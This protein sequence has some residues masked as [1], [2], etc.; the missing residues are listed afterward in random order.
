MADSI[1]EESAG[2]ALGLGVTG[3]GNGAPLLPALA[4]SFPVGHSGGSVAQPSASPASSPPAAVTQIGLTAVVPPMSA[5]PAGPGGFDSTFSDSSPPVVAVH[6]SSPLQGV[7]V[8]GVAGA[9]LLTQIH[10][11]SWD[12]T[13]STDWDNE[14]ASPQCI[15]RIKR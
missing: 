12:P 6:A 5:V 15:L 13:V 7:G 1:G 8:G 14:K 9:G 3:Q 10:A 2:G 11:T 4:S